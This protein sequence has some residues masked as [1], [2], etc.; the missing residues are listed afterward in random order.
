[1]SQRPFDTPEPGRTAVQPARRGEAT[2]PSTEKPAREPA[3]APPEPPEP[4]AP[5]R[6]VITRGPDEGAVF[7]VAKSVTTFGRHRGCDIVLDQVTVSRHHAELSF[8]GHRYI[9]TDSG[10]LNGTYLNRQ[11]VERAEIN[12]GDQIG[13]GTYRLTFQTSHPGSTT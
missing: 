7:P 4:G 10:S 5:T 2:R 1:L 12:H 8:D 9:L 11:P 13:I 3:P 6:L